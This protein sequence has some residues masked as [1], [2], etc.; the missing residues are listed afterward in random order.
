MVFHSILRI[1][2]EVGTA[3]DILQDVFVS[4]YQ[5][6][7]SKQEISHFGGWVKRIGINQAISYLRKKKQLPVYQEEE[8]SMLASIPNPE[9][10]EDLR[11]EEIKMAMQAL[12]T[13]Y[14]TIVNLHLFED[15]SQQEIAQILGISHTTVRTQ[16]IRAKKKILSIIQQNRKENGE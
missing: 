6:L 7:M 8:D 16:Y 9:M 5:N 15:Y 12:S 14:K 4:A 11:V 13:G 10:E 2:G 3:E 1:V